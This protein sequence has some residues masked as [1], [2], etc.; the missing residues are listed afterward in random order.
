M[1]Y[2]LFIY[3]SDSGILLYEKDLLIERQYQMDLFG[4][5]FSALK[6]FLSELAIE[7]LKDLKTIGLGNFTAFV[8]V[9]Y[10]V[11]IDLVIIADKEDSK[12]I[13]KITSEL[14]KIVWGSSELFISTNLDSKRFKSFDR[15]INKLILSQKKLV[16]TDKGQKKWEG[17]LK[18]VYEQRGELSK[19]LRKQKELEKNELLLKREKLETKFLNEKN[20]VKKYNL[21]KK[22]IDISEELDDLVNTEKYKELARILYFQIEERKVKLYHYLH[23]TKKSLGVI[24]DK[25]DSKYLTRANFREVYTNLYAFSSGLKNFAATVLYNK[26][27]ALTR[28]LIDINRL[29][30]KEIN[31]IIESIL[32]MED[33]IEKYFTPTM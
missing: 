25:T 31:R 20:V 1:L 2:Y 23:K 32:N 17:Y 28:S 30:L 16:D 13:K 27:I 7:G 14:K 19:R 26:H 8:I 12:I 11:N 22:I 3:H 24:L 15:E 6:L 4:N 10:E 9:I 21:S 18:P 33:N 29:P 5:L